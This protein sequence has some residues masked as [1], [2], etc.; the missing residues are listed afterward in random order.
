MQKHPDIYRLEA[1]M[2]HMDSKFDAVVEMMLYIKETM[3]TKAEFNR[4]ID[5]IKNDIKAMKAAIADASRQSNRHED[6]FMDLGRLLR[7]YA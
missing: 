6:T 1:L 2:E 7:K 5:E 4:E 3:V